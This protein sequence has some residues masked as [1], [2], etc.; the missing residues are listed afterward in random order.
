MDDSWGPDSPRMFHAEMP[1]LNSNLGDSTPRWEVIQVRSHV[2]SASSN[3]FYY[4]FIVVL[5]NLD[6]TDTKFCKQL[7]LAMQKRRSIL[8]FMHYYELNLVIPYRL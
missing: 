4:C 8:R 5:C 1:S 2:R 7:F 3:E 6:N